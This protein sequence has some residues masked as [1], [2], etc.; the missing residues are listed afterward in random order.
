M[1]GYYPGS[2]PV[3][4]EFQRN[5]QWIKE[6]TWFMQVS[7]DLI[8]PISLW[9]VNWGNRQDKQRC[10]ASWWDLAHSKKD[11]EQVEACN[12]DDSLSYPQGCNIH[13]DHVS[14]KQML[15]PSC[16]L[17]QFSFRLSNPTYASCSNLVKSKLTSF[18]PL[19]HSESRSALWNYHQP[20][21]PPA[22]TNTGLR[23]GLFSLRDNGHSE[24]ASSL[25]THPIRMTNTVPWVCCVELN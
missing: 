15:L 4:E 21:Q 11:K 16:S 22:L 8:K 23:N 12:Q 9:E 18:L 14:T 2:S 1:Q 20:P 25:W 19:S 6:N 13:L 3:G 10:A 5:S 17:Q 24:S 7:L